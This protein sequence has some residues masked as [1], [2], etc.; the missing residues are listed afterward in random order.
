[1]LSVGW[2]GRTCAAVWGQGELLKEVIS[3][4]RIEEYVGIG[5]AKCR[6]DWGEIKSKENMY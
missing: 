4:R 2:Y 5:Q 6:R 1:M 3:K